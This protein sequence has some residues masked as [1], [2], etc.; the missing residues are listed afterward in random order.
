MIFRT[1]SL[2]GFYATMLRRWACLK[3]TSLNPY[4]KSRL[5]RNTWNLARTVFL[6]SLR[7]THPRCRHRLSF[8]LRQ[9]LGTSLHRRR[10]LC[11]ML[12]TNLS[13]CPQVY[14]GDGTEFLR[15]TILQGIVLHGHWVWHP[16]KTLRIGPLS[17]VCH[18]PYKVNLLPHAWT[19][20]LSLRRILPFCK[21]SSMKLIGMRVLRP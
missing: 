20:P 16:T 9:P 8:V 15:V 6:R 7:P 10:T 2:F 18:H 5:F 19:M 12:P 14:A 17:R 21:R 4:R 13:M 11:M 1:E 3:P